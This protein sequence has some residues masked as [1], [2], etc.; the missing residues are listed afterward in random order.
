MNIGNSSKIRILLGLVL[1]GMLIVSQVFA[2]DLE[3]SG[4]PGSTMKTLDEVEPRIPIPGSTKPAATF[5]INQSGSYYLTGSRLCSGTGIQVD[6]NN[7]TI[8]LMGYSLIG[9]DSG[10]THGISMT[11][12]SNVEVRNGTVRDFYH[13]VYENSTKGKSHRFINLRAVSNTNSG[14]YLLGT[15]NL[16]QDCSASENGDTGIQTRHG[17][18][19]T[20]N[21]AWDNGT[22]G[23]WAGYGCTVTGNTAY[24]NGDD[25][26]Y[27][28][29][30]STVGGNTC[31]S[32]TGD[33]IEVTL[34]S[35]VMDNTCENNGAGIHVV[36]GYNHI[37]G[38]TL[39]GSEKGLDIDGAGNYVADN[40]VKGNTDN[41]DIAEGNQLNILLCEVPETIDWPA[42][43]TLAGTLTLT[44]TD[45]HG[46]TVEANDVTIDLGGHSLIGPDSGTGHGIYMK[47]RSNVEIRNGT[48][49][50]FSNGIFESYNTSQDYRVIGVRSVSNRVSGIFLMGSGHLIK[51]CTVRSNG[52]SSD[53]VGYGICAGNGSTVTGN[54]ASGNGDYAMGTVYGIHVSDG[55]TVTGNT[56][57]RNGIMASGS[58]CGIR[59][60][61]GSTVIG[62]MAYGNGSSTTGSEVYGIYLVGYSLVDQNTA[63]NNNT[64]GSGINIH[65]NGDN[66]TFGTNHAP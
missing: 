7:V 24:E 39:I 8:D 14:I 37:K 1:A 59:V 56:T 22:N 65:D 38:N 49:R 5:N 44:A 54:T 31:R 23:I 57:Y 32:N 55:S 61:A 41:Y 4:P 58:I 60:G 12:R 62:N 50:D 28:S 9:P 42:M 15:G 43:V 30:G 66:C 18:T 63:F 11:D 19:V 34:R 10:L 6:A 47:E 46:I 29:N 51:D 35:R 2:G 25:G 17:C 40:I 16:I 3:P 13:G 45:Q 20:G 53:G 21:T 27:A 33:G 52:V 48:V 64:I 26:I 36:Y